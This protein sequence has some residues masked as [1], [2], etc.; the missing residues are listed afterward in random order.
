M[1]D[2]WHPWHGC[3]KISEGCKNCYMYQLDARNNKDGSLIYR[4]KSNFDYPLKKNRQGECKIKSGEMIRVAMTS[5]FFLEEADQW[6]EEAWKIME[7]RQ[8]VIF[9]LLTKR[10]ERIKSCL[11]ASFLR[12]QWAMEN[13]FINVSCENQNQATCGFR[14]CLTSRSDIGVSWLRRC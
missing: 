1:H 14:C 5:D 7:A 9:F 12:G 10:P 2:I 6:R 13:I 8:D 4:S 11:S 3:V